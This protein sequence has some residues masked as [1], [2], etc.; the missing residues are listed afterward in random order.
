MSW[1]MTS[2]R[3]GHMSFDSGPIVQ[4]KLSSFR[5]GTLMTTRRGNGNGEGDEDYR[6]AAMPRLGFSSLF[7]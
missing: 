2:V 6:W 5:K 3:D 4:G 7:N 1:F